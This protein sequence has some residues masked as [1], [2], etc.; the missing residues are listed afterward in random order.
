MTFTKTDLPKLKAFVDRHNE[1]DFVAIEHSVITNL[2]TTLEEL[3]ATEDY[4][5]IMCECAGGYGKKLGDTAKG[6]EVEHKYTNYR[7]MK[8]HYVQNR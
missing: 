6:A 1:E 5:D 7:G 8:D 2:L 4:R 3:W